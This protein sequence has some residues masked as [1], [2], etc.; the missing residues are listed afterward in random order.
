[1]RLLAALVGC[2]LLALIRDI[3]PVS[4]DGVAS[5]DFER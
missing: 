3:E 1:M 2:G 5:L 4:D